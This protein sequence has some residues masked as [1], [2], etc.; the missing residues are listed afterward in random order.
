MSTLS[1][2]RYR[3]R[4]SGGVEINVISLIDILFVLLIFFMVSSSFTAD[5]SVD[6]D[7]PSSERASSTESSGALIVALTSTGRIVLPHGAVT[8]DERTAVADALTEN[9]ATR[10]LLVSDRAVPTGR[11]LEVMDVCSSA[12]ATRVDLA[13]QTKEHP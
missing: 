11:M 9:R 7:R 12:G 13:A 10:V 3:R 2:L 1:A 8:G 5:T 6:I 4:P